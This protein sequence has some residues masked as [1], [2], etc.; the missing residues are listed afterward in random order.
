M[1]TIDTFVVSNDAAPKYCAIFKDER[2]PS[3]DWTTGKTVRITNHEK[4]A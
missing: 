3:Y 4:D 2:Y 1:A